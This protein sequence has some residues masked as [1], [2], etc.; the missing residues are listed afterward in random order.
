MHWGACT[1]PPGVYRASC[2]SCSLVCV[3]C[4]SQ[5]Y[6]TEQVTDKKRLFLTVLEAGKSN[7]KAPA[8]CMSGKSRLVGV[9]VLAVSSLG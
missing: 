7:S 2:S 8:D 3:G 9:L 6:Q 5:K 4:F 1:T